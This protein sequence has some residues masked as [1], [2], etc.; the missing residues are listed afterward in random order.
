MAKKEASISVLNTHE[1][2]KALRANVERL[3]CKLSSERKEWLDSKQHLME[4]AEEYQSRVHF[5]EN[6]LK[7]AK[8]REKSHFLL[9]EQLMSEAKHLKQ[10]LI[11]N[12]KE[13]EIREASIQK[14]KSEI[15]RV[16]EETR[17]HHQYDE[18]LSER[19]T[20][21]QV[22]KFLWT[23]ANALPY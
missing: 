11:L 23:I 4:K 17:A 19:V 13:L 15:C 20:M 3:R 21:A 8:I 18:S 2:R 9:Q 10:D 12:A 22:S 1:E 6:E 7:E 5:I 16:I 14:Y